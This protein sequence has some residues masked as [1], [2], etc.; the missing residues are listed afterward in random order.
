MRRPRSTLILF[1]LL[2]LG[3]SLAVPAEDLMETAYDE[4]ESLPYQRALL[5]SDL[6]PRATA[7]TTQA[8]RS[9]GQG[10]FAGPFRIGALRINGGDA[11]RFAKARSAP[12]LLCTFLC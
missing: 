8:V 3:L 7:A 6:V 5:I 1:V 11:H 2:I 10:Q 9:A 12:A 4:S